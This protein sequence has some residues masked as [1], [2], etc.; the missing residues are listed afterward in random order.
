MSEDFHIFVVSGAGGAGKSTIV[1]ELL[2][3]D[4]SLWR[5]TSW[6][7]RSRRDNEP[8]DA[9]VFVSREEFEA[10]RDRG[11]FI[12]WVEFV[13]NYYATP[14]PNPPQGKD[15]VLVIELE[16]AQYVKKRRPDSLM[17]FVKAP[18]FEVIEER[19][20]QRGDSPERVAAR[21]DKA[22]V[23]EELGPKIADY[24]IINDDLE[25][26]VDELAAILSS[27]RKSLGD[28]T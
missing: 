6:T 19:M 18:S 25:S 12:E 20:R 15:A 7:S 26:A 2:K 13:D 9:Y 28:P 10:E 16:G 22:R 23:E 5:S 3:R 24:V 14:W 21:L 8:E 17:V 1:D 11:G 27:Y 4:S